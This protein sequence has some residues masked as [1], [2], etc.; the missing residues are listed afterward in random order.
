V[1]FRQAWLNW[2]QGRTRAEVSR[3]RANRRFIAVGD[4]GR[5]GDLTINATRALSLIRLPQLW[6]NLLRSPSTCAFAAF[7]LPFLRPRSRQAGRWAA[8]ARPGLSEPAAAEKAATG[9]TLGQYA[10][11]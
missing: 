9:A 4:A 11:V 1:V 8:R 10:A 5:L 2:R 3:P 7:D 6:G